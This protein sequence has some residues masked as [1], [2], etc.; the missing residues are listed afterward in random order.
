MRRRNLLLGV[1]WLTA[2]AAAPWLYAQNAAGQPKQNSAPVADR[3]VSTPG[4]FIS[5]PGQMVTT[6]G[7]TV[8][9]PGQA[10]TPIG[11]RIAPVPGVVAP[12]QSP[13]QV[14]QSAESGFGAG[15]TSGL[16]LGIVSGRRH[17][18]RHEYQPEYGSAEGYAVPYSVTNDYKAGGASSSGSSDSRSMMGLSRQ[19]GSGLAQQLE[20]LMEA[21]SGNRPPYRPSSESQTETPSTTPNVIQSR[22][23][24]LLLVMKN[25]DRRKVRN[26]ALTPQMLMDMDGAGSGKE[27]EIPLSEI[28][29]AA[30]K[31]S[32]AQAGLS[33]AV[34]TN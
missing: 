21:P 29:L 28:N 26:Y 18:N 2:T 1:G 3:F 14:P 32:A 22:E 20:P 15:R 34:P 23:P 24:V 13:M 7:Q 19:K 5:P 10:V 12:F 33:F 16:G 11:Q 31:K 4:Q 25:G 30:T 9:P 6:P 27:V 8:I 17:H